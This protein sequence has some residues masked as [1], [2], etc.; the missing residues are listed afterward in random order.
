MGF[1]R[2]TAINKI[3][4]LKKFVRGV[5]GGTSAGK[6]FGILPILINFAVS[7]KMVEISVVSESVPH[8][9]R[10]AIKD[11]K[12]IM[13]ESGRWNEKRWNATDSKYTFYNGSY[14]EFFS[15]DND[16]KLRG[17]RRDV[18]YI[19]EANNI[20]FDSYQELAVRTKK[21]IYL[22]W[23][24]TAE[25]WFHT[26]LQKDRDTDFLII[27]YLDNEAC[28][29]SAK[30]AIL[31]A[32]EKAKKSPF[33]AN[34]YKVYGLG[35][36]GTLEDVVFSNWKIIKSLPAK[37]RLIGYGLDF[38]YTNDPTA[39]VSI[40]EYNGKRIVKQEAYATK[41]LNKD[42]AEILDG[43]E[44]AT[45]WADSASPKDIADLCTYGFEVEGAEKGADSIKYG[46]KVMQNVDCY[47]VTQD[48]LDLIKEL[49]GYRYI[50]GKPID[51]FNHAIDAL[52]YHEVMNL[53]KFKKD[54]SKTTV[55]T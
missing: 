36:I 34:W 42:I 22:D 3:A 9:K 47:Y 20:D 6:T 24:P 37:A 39:L 51:A 55:R 52:R 8:L 17:A 7:F 18:L 38:G 15:A 5:Q 40:W 43:L 25:F 31:K 11:F 26:E 41:L 13:K 49:R 14:I 50:K 30:R 48:S 33:W 2:T 12:K 27:N 46:I 1:L 23:N 28:P 4:K 54:F 44:E 29:A 45:I 16:S 35:L 53:G 10:G 21:H 32:K 19:N